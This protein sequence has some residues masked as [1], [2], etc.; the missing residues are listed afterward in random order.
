MPHSLPQIMQLISLQLEAHHQCDV[1]KHQLVI[2]DGEILLLHKN[3]VTSTDAV[4][5]VLDRTMV[6]QGLTGQQWHRFSKAISQALQPTSAS[7]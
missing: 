4:I 7:K 1:K 3:Q 2:R 5:V 6:R